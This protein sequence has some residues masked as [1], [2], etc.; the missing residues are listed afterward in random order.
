[1][2]DNQNLG[3]SSYER[4]SQIEEIKK[5]K[6]SYIKITDQDKTANELYHKKV[7]PNIKFEE[8]FYYNLAMKYQSDIELK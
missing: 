4:E 3:D 6:Y 5:L 8:D 7:E 2:S 1:M